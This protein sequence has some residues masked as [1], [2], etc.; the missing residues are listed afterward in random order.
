MAEISIWLISLLFTTAFV[1][2]FHF[3]SLTTQYPKTMHALE[4]SRKPTKEN[5]VV[6][7][8][9]SIFNN[10]RKFLSSAISSMLLVP[11]FA[12]AIYVIDDETGEYVEVKESDWQTTWKQRLDKAKTMSTDEVFQAAR[13]AGNTDLREGPE[14]DASKKRR[15]MSACRDAQT[16]TK[17]N[18]G[19]EKEC[20]A[21]VFAGET[22]FLLEQL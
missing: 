10:R 5:E 13:G 16:R 20:I 1:D 17:A 15:A 12:H 14:S 9:A 4:M 7:T 6:K 18:A 21:R 3:H 19:N 8:K 11:P 22:D 2:A